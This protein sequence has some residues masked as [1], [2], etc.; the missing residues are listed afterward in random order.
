MPPW[1][2]DPSYVHFQD[3]RILPESDINT[4]VDWVNAGAPAGNLADA[5]PAPVFSSASQMTTIDQTLQLPVWTVTTDIDQ[6]R[7]FVI[8]AGASAGK[9]LNQVEYLPGNNAIVHHIVI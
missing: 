1:K 4:L 8:P 7:S 6:Y 9:Y 5:P 3:E 2:P